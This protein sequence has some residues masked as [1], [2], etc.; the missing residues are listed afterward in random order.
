MPRLNV[1]IVIVFLLFPCY[2]KADWSLTASLASD[3]LF[4]G[5][6]QTDNSAAVQA[7]VTWSA[8][9]GFYLGS[10]SSNVKLSGAADT[11]LDFYAGY[12][13]Q[14]TP[15]TSLDLGISQYTYYGNSSSEQLNYA[16]S[17]IKLAIADTGLKLWY[18][19]NYFGT[20]ARHYIV[21]LDHTFE[22]SEKLSLLIAVDKSTSLDI[23]KWQWQEN[24]K[25]YHHG[26][27]SVLYS[28]QTFEV[29]VGIHSTDLH[30]YGETKFLLT[31]SKNFTW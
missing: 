7:G 26:Q 13:A 10:W 2:S 18:S 21:M 20:G 15:Q 19:N 6:S 12:F 14:L 24:D 16:E 11:E 5:I 9:P 22:L 8:D 3:Y 28:Y 27:I 23:D 25:D 30:S 17:Y 31:L 4:N 29:S 1:F